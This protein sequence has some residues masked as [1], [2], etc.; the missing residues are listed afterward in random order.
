M[1]MARGW[2]HR[3]RRLAAALLLC[4]C[5]PATAAD[6][7]AGAGRTL[8]LV[9][10]PYPPFVNPEGDPQG[11]GIDVEIAREAL[12]RGGGF[13]VTMRVVPWKRALAMLE[14]GEADFTTTISRNG[15][16]SRFLAWSSGYRNSV[17]YQFY[18][19]KGAPATL[20]GLS[21]L[22]GH[23]LGLTL[24]FYYPEAITRRPGL[25][26]HTGS[27]VSHTV[28]MLDAGRTDFMVVNGLAGAW[29]IR[30]LG[31]EDKLELQPYFYSSDSPTYM[32]F[33]RARPFAAPLAAM[34]RG[35]QSM[36]KDGTLAQ[37]EKKYTEKSRP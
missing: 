14:R 18:S 6:A 13:G 33:S 27:S 26:L 19:R 36:A 12:R 23:S 10:A 7:A 11:E 1:N 25:V 28:Q 24:G 30:R 34:E 9:N 35:L 21:G 17:R 8:L 3:S 4:A 29:A 37:I 16:R 2:R 31:L 15:D 5:L 20:S 32:A 22:D